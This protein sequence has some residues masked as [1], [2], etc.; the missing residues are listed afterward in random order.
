[1]LIIELI[2]VLPEGLP[3]LLQPQTFTVLRVREVRAKCILSG[4]LLRY[5]S[6]LRWRRTGGTAG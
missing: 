6:W 5:L 4:L 1:M 3:V 2:I